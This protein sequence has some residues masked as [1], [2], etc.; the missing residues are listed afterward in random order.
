MRAGGPPIDHWFRRRL[1]AIALVSISLQVF[2]ALAAVS[3]F[4]APE[5]AKPDAARPPTTTGYDISYPQCPASFPSKPAFGIVG[6]NGGLAYAINRCLSAEYNWALLSTSTVQPRVSFYLNT[7]NPGPAASTHWPPAGKMSP[8]ACDGTWSQNCAYDYGW[9]AALDSFNKAVAVSNL[10]AAQTAPWWLDVET[11]N[12]WSSADLATNRTDLQGAIEGL[13][14][15]GVASIGVYSTASMWLQITGLTAASPSPNNLFR[16]LP[17][18]V[19]GAHSLKE[20]ASYC[21]PAHSFTGG[22]VKLTQY[23]SNGFDA[24]Y[25]CP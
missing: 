21:S 19:P 11:A 24:D 8:L 6:V 13:K 7:G 1:V 12:S 15:A 14:S 2:A 25:V 10:S 22:T 17:N 20:A 5:P 3:A 16:E 23:P 4:A 18:W 9:N